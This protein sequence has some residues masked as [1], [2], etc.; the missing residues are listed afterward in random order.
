MSA[1]HPASLEEVVADEVPCS[2]CPAVLVPS[3]DTIVRFPSMPGAAFCDRCADI[4]ER[5]IRDRLFTVDPA[6]RPAHH[7]RHVVILAG[8]IVAAILG[9]GTVYAITTTLQ[10]RP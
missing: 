10:L 2:Y 4:A 7:R 6:E 5:N 9:A 3:L 8:I 1:D